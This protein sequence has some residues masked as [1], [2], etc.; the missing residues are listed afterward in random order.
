MLIDA[1]PLLQVGD[2]MALSAKVD[3]LVLVTRLNIVR[4]PMLNEVG[5]ALETSRPAKLGFIATGSESEEA[6]GGYYYASRQ[7]QPESEAPSRR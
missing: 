3:G 7:P 4:R 2:A 6:Y 5:R 1:P